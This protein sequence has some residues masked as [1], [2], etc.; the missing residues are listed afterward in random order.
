[1][2]DGLDWLRRQATAND[3]VV[4]F[5][6]G[7]GVNDHT[8]RYYFVPV[9]ADPTR[10][11]S[12]GI[13]NSDIT[14]ALQALPSKVLAFLDTCHAGNVL[15]SSKQRTLAVGAHGDINRMVNELTSAE[16]GVVVFASSTGRETSQESAEW[17][18]GVFTKALVEGLAGKADFNHD[19]AVSLN[20]LNLYVADRVKQLTNGDQHANMIRPDSIRDFPFAAVK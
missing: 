16:N 18:N 15:G 13:P 3:L 14:E 8:N 9:N 11:R 4:L 17:N 12:T 5:L 7:H 2:I 10:M 20:E 6:A 1:V 19:D